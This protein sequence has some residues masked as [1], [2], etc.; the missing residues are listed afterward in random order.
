[1]EKRQSDIK[2]LECEMTQWDDEGPDEYYL[3]VL[4]GWAV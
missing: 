2:R 3:E 4:T 1:M